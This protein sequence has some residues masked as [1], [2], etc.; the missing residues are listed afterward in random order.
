MQHL[1]YSDIESRLHFAHRMKEND[2]IANVIWFSDEAHFHLNAQVNKRNCRFWGSE[3][4][5]LYLEKPLHDEKV[6]AWAAM[7]SAGF[8]GPFVFEDGPEDVAIRATSSQRSKYLFV[9][10]TTF[11]CSVK[12]VNNAI[13]L[14]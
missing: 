1:K 2:Q 11:Y 12:N 14:R 9:N 13:C 5:D 10:K 6:T 3:K 8:I 7:I 4:P